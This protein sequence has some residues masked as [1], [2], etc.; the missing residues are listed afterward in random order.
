MGSIFY[1]TFAIAHDHHDISSA[2]L[3]TLKIFS[4]FF[5]LTRRLPVMNKKPKRNLVFF[6][7]RFIYEFQGFCSF[8]SSHKRNIFAFPVSVAIILISL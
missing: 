5:F 4:E 6:V 1:D 2:W 7:F 8:Y 3:L